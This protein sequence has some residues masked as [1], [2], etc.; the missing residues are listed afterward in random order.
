[1]YIYLFVR[2]SAD[3]EQLR[4]VSPTKDVALQCKC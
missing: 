1:M 3:N 4:R 2:V